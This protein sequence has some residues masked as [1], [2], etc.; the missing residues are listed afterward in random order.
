MKMYSLP[1]V[2]RFAEA[3]RDNNTKDLRREIVRFEQEFYR[4]LPDDFDISKLVEIIC[5]EFEVSEDEFHSPF[6]YGKIGAA[7]QAICYILSLYNLKSK[8]I[9]EMTGF[10]SSRVI[11][12]IKTVKA[13][14]YDYANKID[15]ITE[16]IGL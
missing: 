3:V 6:K 12:S 9:A 10:T 5:K 14:Y 7:R 11:N 15:R 8:E 2:L 13:N 16:K 1:F 4:I